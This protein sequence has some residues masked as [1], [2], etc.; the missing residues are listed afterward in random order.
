MGATIACFEENYK[1]KIK[2]KNSKSK[3]KYYEICIID[4]KNFVYNIMS[5]KTNRNVSNN[6]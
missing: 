3:K 4:K 2:P 6:A 5:A 1:K